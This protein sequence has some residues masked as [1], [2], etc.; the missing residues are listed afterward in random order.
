M[1]KEKC[2]TG[3]FN[4]ANRR[5][6]F[7]VRFLWRIGFNAFGVLRRLELLDEYDVVLAYADDIV[8]ALVGEH[9]LNDM[10][11]SEIAADYGITRQAAY[12]MIRR[13]NKILE[14]YEDR[15]Q[16]VRKFLKTKEKVKEI[17]TL[18]QRILHEDKEQMK[19]DIRQIECVS[20][21][22]LEDL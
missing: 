10:T 14:G 2:F 16:L 22:I 4:G 8:A 20:N 18:S 11:P 5:T 1:V 9:I 6:E 17:H 21:Q 3:G 7:I 12:D 19:D 15:L 13:C